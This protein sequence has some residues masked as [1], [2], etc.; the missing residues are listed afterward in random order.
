VEFADA[1]PIVV[2]TLPSTE[3]VKVEPISKLRLIA[4]GL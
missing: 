4:D 1:S 2:K 3:P